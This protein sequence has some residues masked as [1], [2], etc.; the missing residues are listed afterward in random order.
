MQQCCSEQQ[1][2]KNL[3]I[4]QRDMMLRQEKRLRE[5]R[6]E[7][8]AQK[9]T[10]VSFEELVDEEQDEGKEAETIE[11]KRLKMSL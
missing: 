1:Q 4:V 10:N 11:S 9:P 8:G 6:E 3:A 5:M 2:L 7:M